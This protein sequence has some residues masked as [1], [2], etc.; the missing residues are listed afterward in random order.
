MLSNMRLR[1]VLE[2]ISKTKPNLKMN[3][4]HVVVDDIFGPFLFWPFGLD[5]LIE[6]I[7]MGGSWNIRIAYAHWLSDRR[8]RKQLDHAAL[9]KCLSKR[10]KFTYIPANITSNGIKQKDQNSEGPNIVKQEP[11][12]ARYWWIDGERFLRAKPVNRSGIEHILKINENYASVAT[13]S[14]LEKNCK[15]V[16]KCGENIWHMASNA[17]SMPKKLLPD[18][19]YICCALAEAACGC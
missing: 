19:K 15:Y 9:W 11:S 3:Q 6:A 7:N 2:P 12:I 17:P 14:T 5:L 8:N 13:F 4:I 18:F 10:K 16:I 1:P